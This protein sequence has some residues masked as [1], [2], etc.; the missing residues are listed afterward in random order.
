M[1]VEVK[2]A[3]PKEKEMKGSDKYE[4]RDGNG[5]DEGTPGRTRKIFVGG[6]PHNTKDSEFRNYFSQFGTIM[7]A[8]VITD[9][10]TGRPRGFGFVSFDS[11]STVDK[12]ITQTH[13]IGGKVVEL[14]RAEPKKPVQLSV[15]S[16]ML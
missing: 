15:T 6:L 2:R 5:G 11:E 14:K 16:G 7:E 10:D 8:Q 1:Q 4:S 9:R 12:I 3:V 13:E